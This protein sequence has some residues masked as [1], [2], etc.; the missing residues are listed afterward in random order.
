[1]QKDGGGDEYLG[2]MDEVSMEVGPQ[3]IADTTPPTV[4]AQTPAAGATAVT[5]GSNVTATFSEQVQGVGTSTFTLTGPSGTVPAVVSPNSGNKWTLN[6]S[7]NL[8]AGTT[9]TVDLTTGITDVA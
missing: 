9:Y 5:V 7:A 1:G 4:T 8:A 6:P 2:D 3:T